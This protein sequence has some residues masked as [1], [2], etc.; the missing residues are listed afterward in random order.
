MA[1]RNTTETTNQQSTP[2]TG[3]GEQENRPQARGGTSQP[4]GLVTRQTF[5]PLL[6]TGPFGLIRQLNEEMYR[7]FEAASSDRVDTMDSVLA[8]RSVWV[9]NVEVFEQNG[10]LVVRADLPG[11]DRANVAVE[12]N[13]NNIVISG[14]RKFERSEEQS[15]VYRREVSYGTFY[16]VIPVPEGTDTSQAAAV[17]RNGV[18]EITM[19]A[20]KRESTTRKLEIQ[21]GDA[22]KADAQAR[23]ASATIL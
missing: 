12:I 23:K 11:I 22:Q 13:E 8:S 19:P 6:F 14:E 1:G 17:F 18:L 9:P 20:P 3:T 5:A 21:D 2:T 10:N 15:G 7:L 16:R 4:T